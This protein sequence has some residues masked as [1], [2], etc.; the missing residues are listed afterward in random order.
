MT[1]YEKRVAKMRKEYEA[2][3]K[4]RDERLAKEAK[5]ARLAELQQKA[6][7]AGIYG[8]EQMTIE[9]LEVA[10]EKPG[11]NKEEQLNDLTVDE[12][13][14]LAKEKG[15]TGYSNLAKNELIEALEAVK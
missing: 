5:K 14:V 8:Y 12:L 2:K 9:E 10:L 7:E 13:K 3:V 11:D 15:L 1:R 6:Q 4:V